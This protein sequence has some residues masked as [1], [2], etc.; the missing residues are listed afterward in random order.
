MDRMYSV[1]RKNLKNSGSTRAFHANKVWTKRATFL[2]RSWKLINVLILYLPR[3]DINRMVIS[4]CYV[5]RDVLHSKS[6]VRS[7]M[8]KIIISP[9]NYAAGI[10][11]NTRSSPPRRIVFQ[12]GQSRWPSIKYRESIGSKSQGH[13][14]GF[15]ALPSC[16]FI[17]ILGNLLESIRSYLC[18]RDNRSTQAH[19]HLKKSLFPQTKDITL[20]HWRKHH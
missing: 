1:F 11:R 20:V 7:T 2:I 6:T 5:S 18:I 19:L 9:C 15:T 10:I 17:A 3:R 16:R 4:F 8:R 13:S 14:H 12:L